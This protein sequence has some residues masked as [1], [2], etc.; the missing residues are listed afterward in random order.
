[1]ADYGRN[2][3]TKSYVFA[4]GPERAAAVVDAE[5][6]E[7]GRVHPSGTLDESFVTYAVFA[8]N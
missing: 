4:L 7:L 8:R 5:L 3:I 6:A 2:L 1:M